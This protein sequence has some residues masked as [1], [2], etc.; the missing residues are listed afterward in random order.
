MAA[1]SLLLLAAT[2][3]AGMMMGKPGLGELGH[4]LTTI[5]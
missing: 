4:S 1:S 5:W 3:A 2:T